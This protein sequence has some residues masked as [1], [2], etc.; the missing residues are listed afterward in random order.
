MC[1]IG[2][3]VAQLC[4]TGLWSWAGEVR[5][6]LKVLRFMWGAQ[7]PKESFTATEQSVGRTYLLTSPWVHVFDIISKVLNGFHVTKSYQGNFSTCRRI[8][9]SFSVSERIKKQKKRHWSHKFCADVFLFLL[10]CFC[11]TLLSNISKCICLR[12]TGITG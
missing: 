1:N 4:Q 9:W 12:V 2:L 5:R 8:T 3:K 10:N 7:T 11:F 6:L